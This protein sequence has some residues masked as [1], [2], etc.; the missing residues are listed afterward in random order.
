MIDKVQVGVREYTIW[1]DADAAIATQARGQLL[2]DEGRIMIDPRCGPDVQALT[3]LH[4]MI[5]AGFEQSTLTAG[6]AVKDGEE[7][8]NEFLEE[9]LCTWLESLI[10]QIVK[11]NPELFER[12]S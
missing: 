2:A 6:K 7:D 12:W 8:V 10:P 11:D 5:H 3:I 9:K 4:E 1:R